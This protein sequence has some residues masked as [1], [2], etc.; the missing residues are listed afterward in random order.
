MNITINIDPNKLDYNAINEEV[1]RQLQNVDIL[2]KY[3][4][5][6]RVNGIL[7][8]LLMNTLNSYMIN[9]YGEYQLT[10]QGKEIFKETFVIVLREFLKEYVEKYDS[11]ICE[12]EFNKLVDS[13]VPH[14]LYEVTRESMKDGLRRYLNESFDY[15]REELEAMILSKIH[16]VRHEV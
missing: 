12:E 8:C 6:T 2:E 9:N 7:Q 1:K 3:D 14:L 15:R 11:K 16:E 5:E 13:L 10:Y 4:V